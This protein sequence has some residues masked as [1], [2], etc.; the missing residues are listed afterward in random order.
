[1]INSRKI[2]DLHPT[3]R[4]GAQ[5]LIRRMEIKH[6]KVLI[7]STYRDNEKQNALYAQ[8]RTTAGNI[9]TNAK[10]GQSI[11]NYKTA[12][13]ICKNTK[14]QEYNDNTFFNIAGKLWQEMGGEWGGAWTAFVDKPHFQFTGGLSLKQLQAGQKI[15]NAATMKWEEDAAMIDKTNVLVN[16]KEVEVERIFKNETNYIK[17]RDLEKLGLNVGYDPI[18]K[19]P[20]LT[21]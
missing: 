15:S 17:L 6:Y 2:E 4:R 18:R 7:T 1:M 19:M 16:G 14:G 8:G 3:L 20:T 11:H 21:L 12:F 5:E 13:D 9:V 10:G